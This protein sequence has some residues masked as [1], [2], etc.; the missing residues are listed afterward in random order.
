[1]ETPLV[2]FYPQAWRGKLIQGS[3]YGNLDALATLQT[4]NGGAIVLPCSGAEYDIGLIQ[5]GEQFF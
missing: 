4:Y 1:M 3:S 5:V 2:L